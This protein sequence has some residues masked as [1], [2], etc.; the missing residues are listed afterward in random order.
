MPEV[1]FG[2]PFEG[3]CQSVTE[4]VLFATGGANGK[5]AVYLDG[6]LSVEAITAAEVG[7]IVPAVHRHPYQ[8]TCIAYEFVFVAFLGE[9]ESLKTVIGNEMGI[10]G[11]NVKVKI[12]GVI[13]YGVGLLLAGGQTEQT[14]HRKK[15]VR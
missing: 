8:N 10:E 9:S 1:A 12:D 13:G 5:D 3:I 15:T 7:G 4:V 6:M 14:Y 2:F 11:G